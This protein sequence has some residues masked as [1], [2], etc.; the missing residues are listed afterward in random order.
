L[1]AAGTIPDPASLR[2]TWNATVD[3]TLSRAALARPRD[4]WMQSGGRTGQHTEHLGHLL[5]EM[6]HLQRSYP[7]A[8][9]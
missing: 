8:T 2:D 1:I 9:W 6:Q 3:A 4:G 7:G 5:A